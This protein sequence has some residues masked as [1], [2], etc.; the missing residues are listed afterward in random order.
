MCLLESYL[1]WNN[2]M[3]KE[4]KILM[5]EDLEDDAWWMDRVLTKEK[6]AFTR[7]RVDSKEEFINALNTF[8]PDIILSDHSLPQFNSIEALEIARERKPD[9]PFLIV[10]GS[11]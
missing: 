7:I 10:S 8:N 2:S 4:L 5:L 11:V 1:K 9:V 3:E 6:I